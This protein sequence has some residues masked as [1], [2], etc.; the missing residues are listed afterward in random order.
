MKRTK[1]GQGYHRSGYH[2]G[3]NARPII[4]MIDGKFYA[5]HKA[6]WNTACSPLE[7]DLK[8]YVEVSKFASL[9]TEHKAHYYQV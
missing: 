7:G 2:K 4:Y 9:R 3:Y 6:A 5:K 1:I 8:G